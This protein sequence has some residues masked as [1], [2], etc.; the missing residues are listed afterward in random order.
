MSRHDDLARRD[1]EALLHPYTHLG[2]HEQ[3]GPTII[4]CGEGVWLYDDA[5]NAYIDGLAGLWC[6]TLG[7]GNAELIEAAREQMEKVAFSHLFAHRS[8]EPAIELAEKLKSLSPCP[9]TSKVL[10]CSSGSEANDMQIKLSWYAANARGEHE[11]KK[12]ISRERAY[13]GV[14]IASGSLT[15]LDFVQAD[16]DLPV[17]ERFLFARA[18][19]FYREAAEGEMEEQFAQRL[20]DE[21]EALILREGPESIAMFIAEPVMGAGGV[22]VPPEGYFPAVAE[23]LR[24]YGIRFVSD[25]VIC[26]FGRLGE[27]FGCRKYGVAPDSISVAKAITSA[28]VPLGAVL[29]EE[30][31]FEAMKKE[32][33]KLGVFGHGFT[34]TGHPVAC[35]VACKAIEIYERENM[36]A[37]AAQKAELF[38]RR[39]AALGE[40]PLVGDVRVSGMVGAIELVADKRSKRPFAPE[41]GIGAKVS[42]LAEA[43]GLMPR[44]VAGHN[45]A[46][47]PPLIIS[48][49]EINEMFDRLERAL[50][51]ALDMATREKWA[52]T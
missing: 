43:E 21:L 19:Y 48:E 9:D 22:I 44:A 25:E 12:I 14:T 39:F 10:F 16:F 6:A 49:D 31:L 24:K 4:T 5:G 30:D 33:E 15:G 7:H 13:H 28:Y 2:R 36:P 47:C 23:V 32:S 27:W 40:H 46:L 18:P 38:E 3:T 34:Y 1:I 29:V 41:V 45:I 17:N 11:R 26:G 51:S 37:Q 8:N 20:A 50:D 35:A 42:A 52:E